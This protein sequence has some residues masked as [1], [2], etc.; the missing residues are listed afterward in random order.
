MLRLAR[1][2]CSTGLGRDGAPLGRPGRRAAPPVWR[3]RDPSQRRAGRCPPRAA[4]HHVPVR[5]QRPI[6]GS[7]WRLAAV[8]AE[9]ADV[10]RDVLPGRRNDAVVWLGTQRI[11]SRLPLPW[12][13]IKRPCWPTVLC[14]RW[15]WWSRWWWWWHGWR[16]VVEELLD[17]R[18][19]LVASIRRP[20]LKR[21]KWHRLSEAPSWRSVL[22]GV[23]L[24]NARLL[25]RTGGARYG[26][27]CGGS[28]L[29]S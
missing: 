2:L 6:C 7:W 10:T 14:G 19:V 9:R 12:S 28:S 5:M 22:N 11:G 21:R 27:M 26:G 29:G 16:A 13:S 23:K 18:A 17:A 24:R 25:A 20:C 4:I 8:T 15:W 1:R 3:R